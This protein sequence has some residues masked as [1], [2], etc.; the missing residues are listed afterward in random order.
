MNQQNQL[1]R[2]TEY[3]FT[4][5]IIAGLCFI[6]VFIL[7]AWL[8]VHGKTQVIDNRVRFFAYSTRTP[9]SEHILVPITYLANKYFIVAAVAVLLAVPRTRKEFGVP[10]GIS[11]ALALVPYKLLK[12]SI[13]RPRPNPAMWLVAEHGYSFPS[14]HSMNGM[15][16]YAMLIFL[17]QRSNLSRYKKNVLSVVFGLLIP[18]IGFSRL[19]C[20]VHYVS[21]VLGGLSI[22]LAWVL[23]FP[24]LIDLWRQK[25]SGKNKSRISYKKH[26]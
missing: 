15:I 12:T 24:C 25:T 9:V 11:S 13:A 19:F 8:V 3:R 23:L 10:V 21:D 22:G 26:A 17:I 14:G 6:A 20:G 7:I 16:F 18:L 4:G 5:R 1:Q 2:Q